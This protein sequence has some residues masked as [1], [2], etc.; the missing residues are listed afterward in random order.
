MVE[1]IAVGVD[2]STKKIAVAGV[3][4]KGSLVTRALALDPSMRGAR[5]LVAARTV[6]HAALG[7]HAKEAAI[8]VVEN[9]MHARPNMGTLGI[10]FVV[11]EAAQSACPGAVV[12]DCPPSVWKKQILGHGR[13]D[14]SDAL[15]FAHS[16]GYSGDDDD[17]ADALC[18][19]Q[20]GWVR[21]EQATRDR[22]A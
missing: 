11:I 17:I 20:L 1:V 7:E 4:E 6:A 19:A 12:M 5:R 8:I 2:I 10:A 22:A 16:L 18:L 3:R 13:A 21:W 9:P 15:A 14:K